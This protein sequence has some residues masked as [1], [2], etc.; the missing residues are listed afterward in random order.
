MEL[1]IAFYK[2]WH[3][4]FLYLFMPIGKEF[5]NWGCEM[6]QKI[7]TEQDLKGW[8]VENPCHQRR[9]SQIVHN[10]I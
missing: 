8:L 2:L 1:A 4:E 3:N 5:I 9:W 10:L 7:F 6:N